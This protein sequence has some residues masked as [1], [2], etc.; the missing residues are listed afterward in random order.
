MLPAS[1]KTTLFTR[2]NLLRGALTL[3]FASLAASACGGAPRRAPPIGGVPVPPATFTTRPVDPSDFLGRV[4]LWSWFDLPEDPRS[5]ELSGITWDPATRRLYAVQDETAN[6]VSLLPSP[7]LRAWS[8]GPTTRIQVDYAVDLEGIAAAPGGFFVCSEVGARILEV[9][10]A[11]R[12]KREL[13]LPAHFAGARENKSLESLTVSPSTRVLFTTSESA[14]DC[15]GL[16][17]SQTNGTRVR[18]VRVDRATDAITEHAYASEPAQSAGGDYGIADLAAIS[19]DELFVLERGWVRGVGNTVRVFRTSVTDE[20]AAC[21]NTASLSDAATVV[22]KSLVVDL[23]DIVAHDV[24]PSRQPQATNLLDNFE[25]MSIG[26]ALPDG[27]ATLILVSDDNARADQ[28]ARVV[29]LAF[30][31]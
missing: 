8:F 21:T 20:A 16:P 3:P 9:D 4:A 25:G 7:D 19:D 5:R 31:S 10:H 26:P 23:A 28:V 11:G 15:D 30:G 14:L 6:I 22:S 18:L 2:R 13:H 27:R 12:V 1:A 17:A 29:V 24:P